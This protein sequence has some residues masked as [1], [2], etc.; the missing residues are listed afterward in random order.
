MSFQ[1]IWAN[2]ASGNYPVFFMRGLL[3]ATSEIEAVWPFNKVEPK[4]FCVSDE[5]V[6][7]LYGK[8]LSDVRKAIIISPGEKHKTLATAK[9][10]W[11]DLADAGMTRA[12]HIVAL[13]GGVIGDL[14]G[15]CAATYQ[16]GVPF[17]QIPTTLVSQIDSAYGGKT[18]VDLPE[19]KNYIGAYHQPSAVFVDPEVLRTLPGEEM[20]A[21]WAEVIRTALITGGELWEKVSTADEIDESIIVSCARKKL[22]LVSED[23]RDDGVR[24]FLNLGHT[25]GHAIETATGYNRY[26]HGE[27]VGL[28]L[29]V[30]LRLSHQEEL[31]SQVRDLLLKHNLPVTFEGADVEVILEAIKKDKKRLGDDVP[32]VLLKK[33]GEPLIGCVVSQEDLVSAV[34]EIRN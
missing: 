33:L 9:R 17:I 6:W 25:V 26:R 23:E 10:I 32:F 16:R 29:L 19:A 20:S 34:T 12:D 11:Q 22:E 21:G 28:G 5:H 14:T 2:A 7:E 13:G 18:G 8:S 4:L 31:R 15:F 27:A 30:A 24:Q 1:T 3:S